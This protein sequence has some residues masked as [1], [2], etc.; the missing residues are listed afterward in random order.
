MSMRE[1]GRVLKPGG[2]AAIITE[3][4]LPDPDTRQHAL[5]DAEYFN[6]RHLYEYL[7]RPASS[8]RLVQNIDFSIPDYYVRRACRLPEEAG[9]P[10][11]GSN[12]PHIVLR[13]P[14]GALHT[15]V[16]LFFEKRLEDEDCR[17]ANSSHIA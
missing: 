11:Q 8:L 7:V 13:S 3:Y 14:S 12:K 10:H 5:F 1:I 16:A 4:V 6:L 2:V 9:A 17:N 15:S